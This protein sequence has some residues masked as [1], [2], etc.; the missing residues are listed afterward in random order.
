MGKKKSVK[1]KNRLFSFSRSID[2]VSI[3]L[4]IPQVADNG[5]VE[6]VEVEH[7]FKIDSLFDAMEAYRSA[8]IV[9]NANGIPTVSQGS[10]AFALWWETIFEVKNYDLIDVPDWK[11]F[12]KTNPVAR[13]HATQAGDLLANQL[14]L[15]QVKLSVPFGKSGS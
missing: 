15:M 12:F 13:E 7:C 9:P 5:T 11:E 2:R 8:L 6:K 3:T 1:P 14:G 10:A 4:R